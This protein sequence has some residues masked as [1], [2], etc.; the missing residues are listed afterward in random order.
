MAGGADKFTQNGNVGAVHTDATSVDRKAQALGQV[1]VD[2][3]II[4]FR[5][6]I[7]LRGR[8]A[9]QARRIDWPGRTMTAPGSARQFVELLPIAFLPSRHGYEILRAIVDRVYPL[10]GL[11]TLFILTARSQHWMPNFLKRFSPSA[12]YPES[13]QT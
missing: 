9:I 7:A 1:E 3:S 11:I 6:A 4:Q 12:Q 13:M 5:Q 2:S 8:N 10:I